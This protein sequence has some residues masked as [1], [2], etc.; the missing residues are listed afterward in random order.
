MWTIDLVKY[1]INVKF[2]IYK[3]TMDIQENI[4][5]FRKT[6]VKNKLTIESGRLK[7]Y[8]V[9]NPLLIGSEKTNIRVERE[10]E[11]REANLNLGEGYLGVLYSI[12]ATFL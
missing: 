12:L 6:Q 10:R 5:V 1:C 11:N 7:E 9:C 4:L 3:Y 2:P 8:Q